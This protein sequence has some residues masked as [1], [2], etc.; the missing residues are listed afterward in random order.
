MPLEFNKQLLFE[1]IAFF[2][3]E[4]GLKIGELETAAGVSP[5]YISRASKESG[6]TPGIEFIVGVSNELKV[7]IDTLISAHMSEMTPTERYIVS[8]L[9]KLERD[10]NADKLDWHRE[11]ATSLNRVETD[12]NGI[13]NHPLFSYETFYEQTDGEYPQEMSECRFISHSFDVHTAAHGDCFNLRLKNGALLYLMDISKSVYRTSDP[14][15]YAKEVWLYQDCGGSQY[16]CCNRD[17]APIGQLVESL[18]ASV[19]ENSKHPKIN[20]KL[21]YVIDAFMKDDLSDDEDL[22]PF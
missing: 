8:F 21:Q 6:S 18:F 12:Q 20:S 3:R 5:G 15:A 9:E 11:S 2:V 14:Q 22:L 16:L 7:S 13:A 1:N 17:I 10:T 4:R 19:I